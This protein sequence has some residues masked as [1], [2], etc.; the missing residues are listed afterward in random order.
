MCKITA[1]DTAFAVNRFSRVLALAA[2]FSLDLASTEAI[3]QVVPTSAGTGT[4]VEV[5]GDRTNISGGQL[6]GDSTNL[7]HRFEQFDLT[8]PETANFES[9]AHVQNIFGSIESA[10]ASLIDG[11][12]QVSGSE[13]NLYLMNPAGIL[14]GPSAQLNLSGGFTATT[15]TSIGFAQGQF[16]QTGSDY[17]Y[18]TGAPTS[19][20]FEAADI[21]HLINA[22][23]L[24]V[25]EGSFINLI[26]DTVVNTGVLSAPDGSITVAAVRGDRW[27]RIGQE[28]QIV[29]LEIQANEL[30]PSNVSSVESA[31]IAPSK[32]GE[33]LTGSSLAHA[34]ELTTDAQGN[35]RLG[36]V[37]V[38]SD[39]ENQSGIVLAS[40]SLTTAGEQGGNINVLGD[41]I[42]L[43]DVQIDATGSNGGGLVRI[44]GDYQGAGR[45]YNAE[46]T[47]IDDASTISA[48]AT[49]NGDG[50]QVIVWADDLTEF[51][52]DLRARGGYLGG[53]GGFAEVSGKRSLMM[54][55]SADLSAPQGNFGT[56]LL[57]P[58]NVEITDGTF[59]ELDAMQ[60]SSGFIE[61]LF[62]YADV[63]IIA[64]N[65]IYIHDVDDNEINV[66]PERTIT[67]TANSDGVDG[68]AFRMDSDISIM[69]EGGEVNITGAGISAGIIDTSTADR[70]AGGKVSLNSTRDINIVSINTSSDT[71]SNRAGP[72]G[73]VFLTATGGDINIEDDLEAL[74]ITE[75]NYADRGGNIF[76]EASGNITAQNISTSSITERNNAE[77]GGNVTISAGGS[78]VIGDVYTQSMTE[79]NNAQDGGNVT[80]SA[81]SGITTGDI[82]TQSIAERNNAM[83]GGVVE[84]NTIS[85]SI[86]TEEISTTSGSVSLTAPEKIIVDFIDA[87]GNGNHPETTS[88]SV[89]TE[90]TFAATDIIPGTSN[91]LSTIGTTEGNISVRYGQSESTAFT[92]GSVTISG[93]LGDISSQSSTITSGSYL[94]AEESGNLYLYEEEVG[95]VELVHT[96]LPLGETELPEDPPLA[97]PPTE[98]PPLEEPENPEET[99]AVG[100]VNEI[101]QKTEES[102]PVTSLLSIDS[103]TNSLLSLSQSLQ[104][105][106]QAESSQQETISLIAG[107]SN[108]D[109]SESD[110]D[111]EFVMSSGAETAKTFLQTEN[112]LNAEFKQ[113]LGLSENSSEPI[114]LQT[115]QNTLQT[116]EA[117]TAK[118][119]ALVYFYFVD[120][121]L[122]IMLIT[123]S[124]PPIKQRHSDITRTQVEQ[125][126][127]DL[128]QYVANPV[129][130]KSQYLPPAQA[131]YSWMISPIERLLEQENIDSVGFVLETG[132]R[133]IPWASLHDGDQYL[134]ERYSLGI[135]PSFTLTEFSRDSHTRADFNDASVLAMGASQFQNQPALPAVDAEIDLITNQLWQ[136][137]AFVNEGFVLENL[138]TQL[139]TKD[140]S[141]LHLATHATFKS[142][143]LD[144]SYI[145]LWDEQLSLTDMASLELDEADI[146]LMILSACNTAMGDAASEYGFAGFAISSGSRSAVASLWPVSDEGTL[147]FMAQLYAQLKDSAIRTDGLRAAQIS[148]LQGD[149]GISDGRVYGPGEDVLVTLPELAESGRWDFSHPF[150][151][152]AFTMIGNP[153]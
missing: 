54:A 92:V 130:A 2:V 11:T 33:L 117:E 25:S 129:S 85:G 63:E 45:V 51:Y 116:V 37:D 149:V 64:T 47:F 82:Q 146:D 22:G 94:G 104:R 69:T 105:A 5:I 151:W 18:L 134:V 14:M 90:G 24:Q 59:V 77:N 100:A 101:E 50:G 86:T 46:Q 145:Q 31:Q 88:I 119:P 96:N 111:S 56:L 42:S 38:T 75:R 17:S 19:F 89:A 127:R 57:D 121:E 68:G 60:L 34:T 7:F 65:D 15:A 152:S 112:S 99:V 139:Q 10:G 44:G 20:H 80:I 23:Q 135:L 138:Q 141:V 147:G 8:A 40:G 66:L 48:D 16:G 9:P 3:A 26:G 72:A 107:A 74:S 52:G 32:I 21:G 78:I 29:T 53:D 123:G 126:G 103:A 120:D 131:L 148:M 73:N 30:L 93:S 132:I 153:W 62:N 49:E 13:A 6:S 61:S 28:N 55:G 83:N 122:E 106:A 118:K 84:L 150:Y 39:L 137:E 91:S 113:Y 1:S 133:T 142:G 41:R 110:S 27:V 36:S 87:S 102:S 124:S 70:E 76:I 67:F 95:N 109:S 4:A 35:V 140:Y 115:V 144:N 136:G 128:R 79:R 71:D 97:E 12:L 114:T 143:S 81:G 108:S 58:S 125:A 98:D 43:T